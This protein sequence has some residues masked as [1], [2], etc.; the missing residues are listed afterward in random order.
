MPEIG[1]LKNAGQRRKS[2]FGKIKTAREALIIK[3][4]H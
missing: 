4:G 1:Q 2:P 3:G